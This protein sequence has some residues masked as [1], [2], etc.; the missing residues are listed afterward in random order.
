[1]LIASLLHAI[2]LSRSGT[3]FLPPFC[4]TWK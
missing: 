3:S 4:P 2:S 1:M